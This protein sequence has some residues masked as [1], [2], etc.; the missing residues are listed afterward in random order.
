[1][2]TITTDIHAIARVL[3]QGEI[4]AIPTETVYGLAAHAN[5]VD[6][7]KQVFAVKQRPQDHPLILH[8]AQ[9]WGLDRWA[10]MIPYYVDNLINTFWPGPLTIVLPATTEVNPLITGNK[11][12][13]A[14][15]CPQHPLTQQLLQLLQYPLVA[16]SANLF[17]KLSPTTA[18]HVCMN[19]K[20]DDFLILDGGRCVLGI[21]STIVD[22]TNTNGYR[23][24]RH[25]AIKAQ[26][27]A[28]AM[29]NVALLADN[30]IN[31]GY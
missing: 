20:Y 19:F 23:I 29:L 28:Q 24:L 2:S 8:I 5:N 13:V 9:D 16:P 27:L 6:A 25:G 4:A 22:A 10:T 31:T 21:E 12:T 18:A 30:T 3:N 11:P 26:V 7:I 17:G 14:I 1:M 15:R